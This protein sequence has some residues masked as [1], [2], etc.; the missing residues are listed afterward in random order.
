MSNNPSY[1]NPRSFG[2]KANLWMLGLARNWLKIALIL[3]TLYTT[4]PFAA[5]VLMKAGAEGP[6][7]AI[8]TFYKPFCHQF[9]FRSFFLFGDQYVYPRANTGTS[10]TPFETY[11]AEIPAFDNWDFRTFDSELISSARNYVGNEQ[12]GYKIALCERDIST[13]LALL[14]GGIIYSRPRVRRRLRPLPFWLYFFVGLGP[15]GLDGF[16]QLFGYPPFE[17]WPARETLPIFRVTTGLLFGLMSAWLA[18]PHFDRSMKETQYQIEMKLWQ[19]G[20]PF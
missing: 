17:F 7:K 2:I 16:S 20:I 15:I 12:M 18:F 10:L 5:P 14:L 4:L 13:Y 6:A 3:L 1:E 11:A 19:A 9:V 8:Y